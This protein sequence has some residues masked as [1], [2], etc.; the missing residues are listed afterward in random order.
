MGANPG[1][2]EIIPPGAFGVAR[3]L[4]VGSR[5]TGRHAIAY[6]AKELGLHFR[7]AALKQITAEI[8]T[9][10]DRAEL[11]EAEIDSVLRHWVT[12]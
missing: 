5:L 1:S 12:V 11:S 3:K 10:A 8:K 4:I 9:M 7:E 6:R 2:Y